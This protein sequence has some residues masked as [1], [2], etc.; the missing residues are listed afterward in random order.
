VDERR[1]ATPPEA[2]RPLTRRA[3]SAARRTT[4]VL[5]VLAT[6]VAGVLLGMRLAGSDTYRTTLGEVRIEVEP[7]WAG[8]VD[9]YVPIADWGLRARA[10]D[11]PVRLRV[12]VRSL[13]RRRILQAAGG[14]RD[15]L[16]RTERQL[17]DAAGTGLLRE[18]LFGA[19][20]AILAGGAAV[21]VLVAT[22][23]RRRRPLLLAGAAVAL[24]GVAIVGVSVLLVRATF[25]AEAFERPRFYANGAELLQLLDV[26]T[27]ADERA[28]RYRSKVQ[29]TLVRVS[30]LLADTDLEQGGF[31][32]VGDARR[33]LLASD[34]HGNG[35]VIDALRQLARGDT[36]IF[37]AGDFGH[38]GSEAEIRLVAPQL[39]RLGS[40]AVAVSGNHDSRALMQRLAEV[41]VTVLTSEGRLRPDG[42]TDGR[43]VI[44]VAGLQVAGFSDPLEWR[45]A[46]ADD[47]ER[48]FSFSELEDGDRRRRE[49]EEALVGWF[50]GL[51]QRPEV[52]LVHQNGLAQHLAETL[53]ARPD[54]EALVVLTG[55][56][57]EQHV[58]RHGNV[59]VVDAGSVGAG[60]LFGI[61]DERVGLGD[62]HFA[63]S[64]P[65]LLAVDLIEAE[66]FTGAAAAQR[67]IVAGHACEGAETSCE[68]SP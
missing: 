4:P 27:D 9:A 37:F 12:E 44:D 46:N 47:P 28:A 59:V 15:V 3:R 14:D 42:T 64:S 51:P 33:A 61:G 68:L 38:Q 63:A 1:P 66:P 5:A 30:S 40:R 10:F 34:L 67:V 45:G 31:A 32:D 58:D 25:D 48:I 52:V 8:E 57:H 53:A 49:A 56:D 18:A 29:A 50:D 35:L 60:G 13:N 24:T 26:V 2:A 11:A 36:P 16:Q 23:R 22:G 41:G 19:G 21:L 43:P 7:H 65:A 20:G 17:A 62:L 54:H 55:H 39:G 6:A